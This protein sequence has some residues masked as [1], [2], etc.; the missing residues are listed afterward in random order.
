M[1]Q[2]FNID[3]SFIKAVDDVTARELVA[4]LCRAELRGQGL[5]ESA[6]T[7]GG[8]Q[9]AK[10]GGVDVLVDC[11]SP[12]W[13]PD[14]VKT[15]HTV[16]QVK[17][18]S[19][20]P[21]KIKEEMAPDGTLR[22]AIAELQETRGSY[23]IVSTKDDDTY[24]ALKPR[25]DA[26][27]NCL[28]DHG[29]GTSVQSDFYDSRR[30]ADWVEQHPQIAA[31]LRHKIGEPIKGWRPYGA[32]AYD[33]HDLEAEYL[34][35]DQVRVFVP[36]ADEGWCI[37]DAIAQ[38]RQELKQRVSIR[39]VGLSGVGKTRLVQAL[40]DSRVCPD[41][42]VPSSENVFYV[43]LAD[44]PEPQPQT[45]LNTLQD[46]LSDSIVI[47]DN[48]SP[49]THKQLIE[50]IK[51]NGS[52]LKL[53]TIEY[54][55]R[56]DL[57]ESTLCY[58]LEGSS[59]EIITK[60]LKVRYENLSN[61]DVKRIA[62]FSNGNA[63]MAFAL[64]SNVETGGELS[65]LRDRDLFDRVFQQKN[66]PNDELL[67]C[68]QAASLLYSFDG[69]DQ[70]ENGEISQL[71]GFAEV[72]PL[73]F[74]R[75]IAELESRGLLQKRGRWRAL[76]PH[77]IANGLAIRMLRYLPWDR[78][79]DVLIKHGGERIARSFSK[80]LG[81]LHDCPEAVRMASRMLAGDGMLGNLMLLTDF[82]QQMFVNL[83]PV[84]PGGALAA[85]RRASENKNFLST[86]NS[87]RARFA[88]VA[89]LI[90]YYPTYF[91]E[92]VSILIIFA[93]AEPED[94]H[95]EPVRD[96]LKSLFF[97]SLSGTKA[98]PGQRHEVVKNLFLTDGKKEHELGF[99]LIHAGLETSHFSTHYG[100]EFGARRRDYGWHPRFQADIKDWFQPWIEII[101]TIGEQDNEDGSKARTMLGEALPG[102][103]R[104][105]LDDELV[106]AAKFLRP[107]DGWPEGWL[108]VRRILH[109][110]A[111]QL[112]P[113]SLGQLRKLEKT[114]KPS[115][116]MSEIRARLLAHGSFAYDIEIED[117]LE[118]E[119]REP[120]SASGKIQKSR[121]K[122]EK[123]GAKAAISPPLIEVLIPDLISTGCSAVIY[124]FGLGIGRHH[125]DMAGLLQ[126]VRTHIER[127]DSRDL[128]LIWVRGLIAGWKETNPDAV[129][130]FLDGAIDDVVWRVWFVELQC[131]ASLN[132]RAFHRLVRVLDSRHCPTGQF[133]YLAL[134][135]VTDPL[136]VSQI[137]ELSKKLTLRPDHGLL[138]A[139]E[140]LSM[141]IH[142]LDKKNDQYKDELAKA[143]LE[144]LGYVDW[145]LLN[146]D[147]AKMDYDL[148]VVL[149]FSLKSAKSVD[150]I[151]P[152][153]RSI[154]QTFDN[155]QLRYDQAR[156]IILKLFFTYFPKLALEMICVPDED[157]TFQR[158]EELVSDVHSDRNETILGVVSKDALIDWCN[159]KPDTRYSFVASTCKLFDKQD[160][161]KMS[162]TIS[163]T[164]RALLEAAPNKTTVIKKFVIRFYPSGW[165]GSLAGILEKRLPL[166]DY[167]AI[168]GDETVNLEIESAKAKLQNYI[169][170]V[171][172]RETKEESQN[173][174]FE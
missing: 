16:F 126:A 87:S 1:S 140:L 101:T 156:K 166:L 77:A 51:R 29:L 88:R 89:R 22:P 75:N 43:D 84:D 32:W 63:R 30:L 111:D 14:F 33:E 67:R 27:H 35:D 83:A 153:L 130:S 53:I 122:A 40:F 69:S 31:W 107:I 8:D 93:L 154:L 76:L 164:A 135:R 78:L 54:D 138:T 146:E 36:N 167:L 127:I 64:A 55:I 79:Y 12:L 42:A 163:D 151:A 106:D 56:D 80:R 148:H 74:S 39:I 45:M 104:V 123:L 11:P 132:T 21:S 94:Y 133:G 72:T 131:Q 25:R 171:R 37:E 117:E 6:V 144:F 86:Y 155:D 61:N 17:A 68:A 98:S 172:K 145:S 174:S 52:K 168:S 169:D 38:M 95:Y 162:L 113:P 141:V 136:T 5:P 59:P 152:I 158:L 24:L 9:R 82:E 49:E 150:N 102:L 119:D 13:E 109:W 125:N 147:N 134:G 3:K 112:L 165:S 73:A 4:R 108:G 97:C 48:C 157:G 85:I 121:L 170:T 44:E 26:I 159:E 115:D 90:A 116:L 100:F 58:R 62:E 50:I 60:L 99:D 57:P 143:L 105:G 15:S 34:I 23:I 7:W 103:W 18:E 71:C 47:I 137:M 139:I 20:P 91:D 2:L 120:V 161:E 173:L 19:F 81:F 70:S 110:G 92:A 65:S 114:L 41:S 160:D 128:S 118:V 96:I 28:S 149:E 124:N 10:D 129:E 142:C 46:R 66:D